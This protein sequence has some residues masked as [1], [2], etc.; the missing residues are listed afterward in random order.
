MSNLCEA[1]ALKT[2]VWNIGPLCDT[3]GSDFETASA[4]PG[5]SVGMGASCAWNPL[6]TR[7]VIASIYST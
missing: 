7:L 2:A 6:T 1:N 4:D 5:V 3:I